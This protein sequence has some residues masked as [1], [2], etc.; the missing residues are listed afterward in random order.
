MKYLFILMCIFPSVVLAHGVESSAGFLSGVVH[1]M[2]GWEHLLAMIAVGMLGSQ[3]HSAAVWQVPAAFITSLLVG[4][5]LG[6]SGVLLALYQLAIAISLILFGLLITFRTK[7]PVSIVILVVLFFGVF[8]G[9]AH[10]IEIVGLVNPTGFRKG[11][12]MGSV[13]IHIIGICLGLVPAHYRGFHK[14]LKVSGSGMVVLG[15][16]IALVGY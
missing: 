5:Y 6:E 15:C 2:L 14:G 4:L 9:Y 13:I 12:F 8:H 1:P 10:G 7:I 3:Y 16:W 11:F